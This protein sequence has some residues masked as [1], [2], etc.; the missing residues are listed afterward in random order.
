M[1]LNNEITGN[2]HAGAITALALM[3]ERGADKDQVLAV[4]DQM[5]LSLED[6]DESD[7]EMLVAAY[8]E[9]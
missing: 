4:V 1:S 9:L 6:I 7:R 2:Y 3:A 8:G 5:G